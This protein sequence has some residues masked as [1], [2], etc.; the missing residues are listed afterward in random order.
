[1]LIRK[2]FRKFLFLIK[3]IVLFVI[4][5]FKIFKYY[6]NSINFTLFFLKISKKVY[7]FEK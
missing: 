7:I 3:I 4:N 5:L 2:E 6:S 1:M